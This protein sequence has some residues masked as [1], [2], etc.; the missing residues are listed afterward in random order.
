M[1]VPTIPSQPSTRATIV[2]EQIETTTP[3]R[4]LDT[5]NTGCPSGSL[6]PPSNGQ[7]KRSLSNFAAIRG[8]PLAIPSR[9]RVLRS[10]GVVSIARVLAHAALGNAALPN[11]RDGSTIR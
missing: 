11:V 3:R 8:L 6:H 10:S 4:V 2:V 9:S 1:L 5:P 7:L